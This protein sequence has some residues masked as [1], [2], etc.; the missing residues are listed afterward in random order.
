MLYLDFLSDAFD[1]GVSICTVSVCGD[2]NVIS[3]IP[4]FGCVT[5]V[6]AVGA[7]SES[8]VACNDCKVFSGDCCQVRIANKSL[9]RARNLHSVR[10]DQID[11]LSVRLWCNR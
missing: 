4:Y 7:I 5:S 9:Y 1:E 11:V 3:Y 6:D 10:M 8:S 2:D